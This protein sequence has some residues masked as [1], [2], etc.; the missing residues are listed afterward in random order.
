MFPITFI[1][2]IGFVFIIS[3][4][5]WIP[6][7]NSYQVFTPNISLLNKTYPH[8]YVITTFPSRWPDNYVNKLRNH[9]M[10]K[11]NV[12]HPELDGPPNEPPYHLDIITQTSRYSIDATHH[13]YD[14]IVD[15]WNCLKREVL[16]SY[17]NQYSASKFHRSITILIILVV[18]IIIVALTTIF[19]FKYFKSTQ[20]PAND[21]E[22]TI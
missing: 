12:I 13:I 3:V 8:F 21:C 11:C 17:N 2:F 9:I 16:N 18:I 20:S 7:E 1:G 19:I 4:Q 15:N 5:G 10:Q 14:P 22:I 6:E